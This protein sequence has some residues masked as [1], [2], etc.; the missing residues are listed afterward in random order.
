MVLDLAY[1]KNV[2]TKQR[3]AFNFFLCVVSIQGWLFNQERFIFKEICYVL[4]LKK[5][6]TCCGD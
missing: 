6:V 1:L 3:I 5:L 2:A 4:C